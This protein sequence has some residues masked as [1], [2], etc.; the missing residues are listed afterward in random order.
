ME[1]DAPH[2]DPARVSEGRPT[3]RRP[4]AVRRTAAALLLAAAPVIAPAEGRS[5]SASVQP[6][7]SHWPPLAGMS[8]R[9]TELRGQYLD[10]F[11]VDRAGAPPRDGARYGAWAVFGIARHTARADDPTV[12]I[13]Q[14]TLDVRADGAL[15]LRC[16]TDGAEVATRVFAAEDV[17]CGADGLSLIAYDRG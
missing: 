4:R 1:C 9:C 16:V 5:G 7:P 10:P 14:F 13:R 17:R 2:P 3:S 8:S 11:P 6:Y 15:S 12:A